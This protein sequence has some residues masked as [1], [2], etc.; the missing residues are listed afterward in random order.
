MQ[1]F[2]RAFVALPVVLVGFA[3]ASKQPGYQ[4]SNPTELVCGCH[5]PDTC[6]E[7]AAKLSKEKGETAETGEQLLYFAQCACF[8]GSFAG[9]NT[10]GH[11][12]KDFVQA[13]DAGQNVKDACTIAGFVYLHAVSIPSR[14]GRSF[15]T[16]PEK[17]QASFKRACEAGAKQACAQLAPRRE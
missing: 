13:C 6:Y 7:E 17:S 3:C 12:A 15:H 16:D 11:F 5:E 14:S 9:C 10:L 2:K 4:P 1:G 8:E